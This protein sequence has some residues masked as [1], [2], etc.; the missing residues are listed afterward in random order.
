MNK[1]KVSQREIK[2]CIR[3]V[4]YCNLNIRIDA[5]MMQTL[6]QNS[7]NKGITNSQNVRMMIS[8]EFSQ[9]GG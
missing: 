6:T 2:D 8:S 1:K 7:V 3:R 4:K 5:I 9:G